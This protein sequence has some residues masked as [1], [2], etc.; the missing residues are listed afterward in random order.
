MKE[1]EALETF[2]SFS[3]ATKYVNK[4]QEPNRTFLS[5]TVMFKIRLGRFHKFAELLACTSCVKINRLV[6]FFVI[7]LL[8]LFSN[9]D[10]QP[11]EA[12]DA[13]RHRG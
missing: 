9:K 13:A 7:S 2:V 4:P 8:K 12:S 1:M 6:S 3:S 11:P 5:R 10:R